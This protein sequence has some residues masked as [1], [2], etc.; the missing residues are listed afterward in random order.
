MILVIFILPITFI[1]YFSEVWLKNKKAIRYQS[2][3]ICVAE[4]L[5]SP[6]V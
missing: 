6:I 4:S 1:K 5:K 2:K 3:G